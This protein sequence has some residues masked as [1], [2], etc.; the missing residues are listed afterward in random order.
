MDLEGTVPSEISQ[1]EKQVPYD[2]TYMWN[3]KNKTEIDSD[4]ENKQ[5]AARGEGGWQGD[6]WNSWGKLRGT[7]FQ[8]Q[9]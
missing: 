4:S 6:E 5:V 7:N 9:N 8:L 3:L 2:F 1:T